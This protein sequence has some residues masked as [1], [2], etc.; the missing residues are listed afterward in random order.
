MI[1]RGAS[2]CQFVAFLNPR[3]MRFDGVDSLGDGTRVF[4]DGG[5]GDIN[6]GC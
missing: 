5:Y 2:P 3:C 4:R 1:H 6:S